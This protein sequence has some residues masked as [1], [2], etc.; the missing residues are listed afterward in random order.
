MSEAA[1][2]PSQANAQ[3]R[4]V[5]TAANERLLFRFTFLAFWLLPV[6]GFT[7][8]TESSTHSWQV[9]DLVKLVILAIVCFGGAFTLHANLGHRQFWRIVE[10]LLPF[11]VFFAWSFLSTLWSPLKSV[12]IFQCGGLAALLFFATSIGMIAVTQK[13]VSKI[14]F[15]LC[16]VL[17]GSSFV[18]LL[19]YLIDPTMSGLDRSRIHTGGDGLIHPT[20]AGATASLGLLIPTLCHVI[21]K[22]SWAKK[23]FVPCILIH[24]SIVILSN[25]R[26]ATGMA[27][28]TIGFVLFWYSTNVGRAKVVAAIGVICFALVLLDPG[29]RLWSSTAGASAEY[30]TRGQSGDQLKGVSGRSEMWSAI[31]NEYEKALIIGHGYFVTSETGSLVVWNT[32]HNHTAH[33]LMLQIL[34]STGAIGFIVFGFSLVQS[35]LVAL[36]LRRGNLFQHR[37]FVMAMVASVWYFGWAQLGISFMGPVRPESIV[38]F[39]LL[40]IVVGQASQIKTSTPAVNGDPA[41]S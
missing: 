40:G 29:F 23:L 20:A 26:T 38:F 27:V 37:L 36:M 7:M 1:F 10:P 34:V 35:G 24:G 3:P 14:L 4:A 25:S 8:P 39:S 13:N 2:S 21:G 28:L 16:L 31:W 15:H 5:P 12:T 41:R 19:A 17:L 6:M 33:N 18:V 22:F 32:R 11:Y 30:V 9:L